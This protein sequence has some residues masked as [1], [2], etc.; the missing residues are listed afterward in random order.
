MCVPAKLLS[1]VRLFAPL[2]TIAHQAPLSMGILQARIPEWVVLPS[3]RGSSWPRDQT[4]ISYVACIGRWVLYQW[5]LYHKRH[6]GSPLIVLGVQISG[7]VSTESGN[8]L[9][10]ESER[11]WN[12]IQNILN[13]LTRRRAGLLE[14]VGYTE[15]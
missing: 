2:G 7:V 11:D 8:F 13:W 15:K 1:H 9:D 10:E 4:G 12:M 3:S 6:L 14:R 5:V